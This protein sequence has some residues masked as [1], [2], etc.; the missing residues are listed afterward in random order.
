MDG[1][2][3]YTKKIVSELQTLIPD[4]QVLSNVESHF[5]NIAQTP[6]S[7]SAFGFKGNLKR[8]IWMQT[9]LPG[10]LRKN[11]ISV[12]YSPVPDA[13]MFPNCKQIITIHD[14]IPLI[15]PQ[16]SPRLSYYF[17]TFLPRLIKKSEVVIAISQATKND[18]M[19][20]FDTPAEK[21]KVVHSAHNE[22]LF[23]KRSA[24]EIARMKQKYHIDGDFLLCMGETRPYKNIKGLIRAFSLAKVDHVRLVIAGNL[25][26]LEKDIIGLSKNL[27]IAD[28]IIRLGFVPDDDLACLYSEAKGFVF[29]SFY[30]GFG[31]PP[32]E[33]MACGTP[34]IASNA[35]S[36]PEVCG[37]AALYFN[38]H[39]D[40]EMASCLAKFLNDKHLQADLRQKAIQRAGQF[41]YQK[42]A[43]QIA[44][45]IQSI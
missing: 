34:V 12:F 29:P 35:A 38:P 19:E 41:N 21:I 9:V 1:I 39:D 33:A 3:R 4:S 32:L 23:Y 11:N 44:E 28:N 20:Y 25:G 31:F 18:I 7:L 42:S 14:I 40:A 17:K 27:G 24:D 10:R 45:I 22:M 5:E 8:L 36:I 26:P 6:E 2:N 16:F 30:E 37:E 13:M 15:Y 43:S